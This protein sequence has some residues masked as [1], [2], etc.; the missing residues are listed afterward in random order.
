MKID[1]SNP[2]M[3]SLPKDEFLMLLNIVLQELEPKMANNNGKVQESWNFP[4]K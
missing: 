2:M 3:A 4:P 1:V